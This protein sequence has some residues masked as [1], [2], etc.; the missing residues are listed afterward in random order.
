MKSAIKNLILE[1]LLESLWGKEFAVIATQN[2]MKRKY[3]GMATHNTKPGE[4]PYRITLL[5]GTTPIGHVDLTWEE[6]NQ[7]LALKHFTPEVIQRA[8]D[9]WGD[10]AI[11][12]DYEIKFFPEPLNNG[13]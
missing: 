2:G 13:L 5:S 4:R 3:V 10:D 1:V 9:M 6:I 7:I 12:D 11:A 8:R